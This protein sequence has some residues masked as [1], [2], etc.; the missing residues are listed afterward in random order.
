MNNPFSHFTKKTVIGIVAGAAA[1]ACVGTGVGV[2][3]YQVHQKAVAEERAEEREYKGYAKQ[4]KTAEEEAKNGIF[5]DESGAYHNETSNQT[6]SDYLNQLSAFHTKI[7]ERTLSDADKK[8]FAKLV[9]EIQKKYDLAKTDLE[10]VSRSTFEADTASLGTYYTDDMKTADAASKEA[11]E[12]AMK[13][14]NYQAAMDALNQMN[15]NIITASTNKSDA[16]KK[17]AEEAAAKAAAEQQAAARKAQAGTDAK[18]S[19]SS[20]QSASNGTSSK[21][22]AGKGTGSNRSSRQSA[23]AGSSQRSTQSAST[24]QSGGQSSSSSGK[25]WKHSPIDYNHFYTPEECPDGYTVEQHT[26]DAGF[27][28]YGNGL[29][30]EGAA[31]YSRKWPAW[32]RTVSPG[33]KPCLAYAPNGLDADGAPVGGYYGFIYIVD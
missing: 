22:S 31:A 10:N 5:F 8:G 9:K 19:A 1:I 25:D 29:T 23:S 14:G 7:Q 12:K 4:Y 30:S 21:Q 28:F 3:T 33:G 16:E 24:Q 6:K 17:A 32:K 20:K 27:P 26:T 18:K 15:N 11:Y 13:E 2:H